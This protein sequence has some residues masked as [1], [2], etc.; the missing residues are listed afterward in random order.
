[1]FPIDPVQPHGEEF[2]PWPPLQTLRKFPLPPLQAPQAGA[3]RQ[4]LHKIAQ[5]PIG[6]RSSIGIDG[7]VTEVYFQL[8]FCQI[9]FVLEDPSRVSPCVREFVEHL[10]A[11]LRCFVHGIFELR[12]DPQSETVEFSL[13]WHHRFPESPARPGRRRRQ[14]FTRSDCPWHFIEY[15]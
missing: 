1:M 2:V 11:P 14:H 10:R 7:S 6:V 5:R 15:A 4:L 8:L 9:A 3:H 12:D 13:R